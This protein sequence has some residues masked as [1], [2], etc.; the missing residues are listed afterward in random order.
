MNA[1]KCDR[2]AKFYIQYNPTDATKYSNLF[3][4]ARSREDGLYVDQQM[5]DLCEDC[6]KDLLSFM[7]QKL[8]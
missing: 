4:L 7:R 5:F 1:K 2:C 8:N 3:V 6:M